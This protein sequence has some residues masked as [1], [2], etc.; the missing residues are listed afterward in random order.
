MTKSWLIMNSGTSVAV[1]T[2]ANLEIERTVD[3]RI[4]LTQLLLIQLYIISIF[5]SKQISKY[6]FKYMFKTR[7][8]YLFL[9][10]KLKPN[11]RPFLSNIKFITNSSISIYV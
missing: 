10:R 8:T 2:G 4:R 5:I 9:S 7:L 6:I 3:P 11:I 1:T